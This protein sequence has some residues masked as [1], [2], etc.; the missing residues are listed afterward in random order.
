MDTEEVISH[1]IL[2]HKILERLALVL[3]V[4]CFFLGSEHLG[5]RKEIKHTYHESHKTDRK[6]GEEC[7]G[8]IAGSLE[9]I[10]DDKVGRRTD[11]GHHASH[12]AGEGQR[13]EQA[14]WGRARSGCHADHDR[15]HEGHCTGVADEHADCRCNDH[16]KEEES[17]FAVAC[18]GHHLA[19]DHLCQTG[20]EDAASDDEQAY[21]HDDRSVGKARKAFRRGQDLTQEKGQEGADG[22]EVRTDL[23]ADEQYGRNQ[24][25]YK[26]CDHIVYGFTGMVRVFFTSPMTKMLCREPMQSRSPRVPSTKFW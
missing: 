10:A 22:H 20:L 26:G 17:Q 11:E 9:G 24:E 16:H 3:L 1:T 8:L 2:T 6:E 23:A 25:Y 13:H 18:E 4:L 7:Q 21:H 12:A 15:E 14:A 19:A 5:G